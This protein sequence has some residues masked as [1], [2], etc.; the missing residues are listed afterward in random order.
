MGS[1]RPYPTALSSCTAIQE[2]VF[3]FRDFRRQ[4]GG[5]VVVIDLQ[6]GG[7]WLLP[8]LYFLMR[9]LETEPVISELVFTEAQGGT[10]GYVVGTWGPMTSRRRVEH[11]VPNYAEAAAELS[12]STARDLDKL[13]QAQ[14]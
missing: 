2:L 10:D 8:N 12:S 1:S 3:A 13:D 6:A 7:K 5:P 9:L 14:E 4:G 11:A